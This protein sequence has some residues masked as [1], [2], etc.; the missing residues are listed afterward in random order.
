MRYLRLGLLPLVFVACTDQPT[1]VLDAAAVG[2]PT[3]SRSAV[4]NLP[5][6]ECAVIDG[7]GDFVIVDCRQ[8]LATYSA[9]GNA[10]AVVK[11]SGVA[12][13]TGRTVVWDAYNPGHAML[14]AYSGVLDPPLPCVIP[15]TNGEWTLWTLKWKATVSA[16]GQAT[17]TCHYSKHWEFQWPA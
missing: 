10:I 16:G 1:A 5:D 17:M 2:A 15:D 14:E 8:Q 9:N 4:H 7:N 13:P 6:P 3:F 11:A 12:N